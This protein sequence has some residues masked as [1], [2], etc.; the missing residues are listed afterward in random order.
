MSEP[1]LVNGTDPDRFVSLS[2]VLYLYL[3][4]G[5][6]DDGLDGWVGFDGYTLMFEDATSGKRL[7]GQLELSDVRIED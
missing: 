2:D 3:N 4:T 7:V 6:Y 1:T 5:D